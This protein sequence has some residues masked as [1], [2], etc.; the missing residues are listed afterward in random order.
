MDA[1]IELALPVPLAESNCGRSIADIEILRE[2]RPVI[3]GPIC[4]ITLSNYAKFANTKQIRNLQSVLAT[5]TLAF[6]PDVIRIDGEAKASAPASSL[7]DNRP[8]ME[9][10]GF[11]SI[12]G[13]W[14]HRQNRTRR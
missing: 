9:H 13:R 11:D 12:R 4:E 3:R 10:R 14:T 7:V 5:K 8:A 1:D 2:T 6:R